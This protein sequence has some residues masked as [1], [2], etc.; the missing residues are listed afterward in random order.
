MNLICAGR[1]ILFQPSSSQKRHLWLI[2]TDPIGS[3]REV[4][5]VMVRSRKQYT[6]HTVVLQKG[7]HPFV[8]HSTSVEYSTAARFK[9]SRLQRGSLESDMDPDLLQRVR[10][11]LLRSPYTVR[12]IKRL[13][14]SLWS[15]ASDDGAGST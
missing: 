9:V 7:D 2:L 6:D 4:I 15:V 14:G 5:A 8:R 13:C 10:D 12:A 11:G 1:T 3:S